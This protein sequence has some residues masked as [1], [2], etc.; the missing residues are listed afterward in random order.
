METKMMNGYSDERAELEAL[1]AELTPEQLADV[2]KLVDAKGQ[3]DAPDYDKLAEA[4]YHGRYAELNQ[5]LDDIARGE[6]ESRVIKMLH[7]DKKQQDVAK[8][9]KRKT[10]KA[11]RK[12][13]QKR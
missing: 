4:I 2:Q 8:K 5:K 11:A 7:K 13:A 6:I 1:R 12:K 3:T 10:Q 9:R